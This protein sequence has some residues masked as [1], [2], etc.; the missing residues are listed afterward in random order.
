MPCHRAQRTRYAPR[1]AFSTAV[2]TV[3]S[4]IAGVCPDGTPAHIFTLSNGALQA[5][6]LTWGARLISVLAPDRNGEVADVVL[7]YAD[8]AAY[9]SDD[10]FLGCT[11]GRFAN[12]I[13]GGRF[14]LDGTN[15]S[16]DINNGPNTLHGGA[17]G[18]HQRNWTAE[19]TEDGVRLNLVSQDGDGG[20]PGTLTATVQYRLA[21][22]SIVLEYLATTDQPTVINLTNHAYFNL[23]GEGSPSILDHELVIHADR[24]LA[25][26]AT[27]IP[28]GSPVAVAGTPFD[29]SEPHPIGERIEAN[30]EQ[31]RCGVGY[32]HTFVLRGPAGLMNVAAILVHPASGRRLEIATTEPGVQ[33]YSG[34]HLDGSA[35]GKSERPYG[36]R[37]AFCLE[38]Q[39]FP[40]SPNRPEYP[41]TVLRPGEEFCSTTTLKFSAE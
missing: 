2:V 25:T 7:G 20:F 15:Y 30:N 13:A 9:L 14:A 34:N 29:F 3:T 38:T 17:E 33:F 37:S 31:I 5:E 36:R 10:K 27:G 16:L 6:V 32:D 1:M 4:R 26:E 39:H 21:R 8:W 19:P 28:V 12:R 11:A 40:D 18:F 22:D 35:S 23:A 24:F 41:T